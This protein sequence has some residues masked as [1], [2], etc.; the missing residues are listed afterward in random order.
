MTCEEVKGILIDVQRE[1]I[2][3]AVRQALEKHIEGCEQCAALRSELDHLN[4]LIRAVPEAAPGPDMEE[5]FLQML[6]AEEEA[7]RVAVRPVRCL[8]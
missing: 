2:P 7:Q 4:Q 1:E 5:Q 6:R 8:V 3:S